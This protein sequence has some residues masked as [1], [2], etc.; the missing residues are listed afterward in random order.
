MHVFCKVLVGPFAR[1]VAFAV[2][3]QCRPF[4]I[5]AVVL[6]ALIV[7]LCADSACQW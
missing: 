2:M 7:V 1:A 5:S 3:R 4:S 6:C